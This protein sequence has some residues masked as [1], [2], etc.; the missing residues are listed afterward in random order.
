MRFLILA[1]TSHME[2]QQQVG[3]KKRKGEREREEEI[4]LKVRD[5]IAAMIGMIEGTCEEAGEEKTS[6]VHQV[7]TGEMETEWGQR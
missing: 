5:G 4:G 1:S 7:Q 6:T 2:K 3:M